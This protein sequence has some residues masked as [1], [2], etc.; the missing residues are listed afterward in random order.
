MCG[1]LAGGFGQFLASP[2]DLVKVNIQMDGK[3]MA[4]GL[5]PR[6]DYAISKVLIFTQTFHRFVIFGSC[7]CAD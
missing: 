2:T 1:M 7:M 3:R 5:Q 6:Y 4:E